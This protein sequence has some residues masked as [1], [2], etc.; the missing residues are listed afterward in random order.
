MIR[1]IWS[2]YSSTACAS[3]HIWN[4][5]FYLLQLKHSSLRRTTVTPFILAP[6][7]AGH[8]SHPALLASCFPLTPFQPVTPPDS[9]SHGP[10]WTSRCTQDEPPQSR[11]QICS[12]RKNE[13]M[14]HSEV[15]GAVLKLASLKSVLISFSHLSYASYSNVFPQISEA[16][17][18]SAMRSAYL[19][20]PSRLHLLRIV[21]FIK[22]LACKI[23]IIFYLD[24]INYLCQLRGLQF[25]VSNSSPS[26]GKYWVIKV[27]LHLCSVARCRLYRRGN[28]QLWLSVSV[29]CMQ[30]ISKYFLD[31][32]RS[33]QIS[34]EK[35]GVLL[36]HWFE[37]NAKY[38]TLKHEP[39]PGTVACCTANYWGQGL[40]YSS[41]STDC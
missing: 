9:L 29:C 28:G 41:H 31:L 12:G 35:H 7:T 34:V 23:D 3:E 24:S 20:W 36:L 37:A 13:A 5:A 39:V 8:P 16:F 38:Y 14:L 11:L 40:T 33:A 2:T 4:K 17:I 21:W 6:P 30:L 26:A 27:A 1:L 10:L 19:T 32:L 25:M 15:W 22:P 18:N